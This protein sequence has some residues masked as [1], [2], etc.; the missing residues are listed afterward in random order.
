MMTVKRKIIKKIELIKLNL[1]KKQAICHSIRITNININKKVNHL[2][3][4]IPKLLFDD[5]KQ[6]MRRRKEIEQNKYD[7]G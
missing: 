5:N 2:F 7:E 1:K 4:L 6:P 3:D